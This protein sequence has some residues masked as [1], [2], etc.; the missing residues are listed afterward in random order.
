VPKYTEGQD[1]D[2]AVVVFDGKNT[3]DKAFD[4][5]KS[6]EDRGALKLSEAAVITRSDKGE[7]KLTNKGYVA[8]WKGGTIG[9]GIGLL[10]GGPVGGAVVGGLIGFMRGNDRRNLRGKLSDK[11][12]ID[13]SAL[14]LV[15]EEADW[16]Q[17]KAG[18]DGFEGDTAYVGVKG[19][20]LVRLDEMTED[21]DVTAAA[22]EGFDEV[23]SD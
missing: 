10:L 17:L 20:A 14:A 21:E 2:F 22:E 9:L 6:M 15:V 13:Q 12:G 23:S 18:L 11:L 19:E 5:V 16:D 3:A 4:M 1:Y 7:I 8:G